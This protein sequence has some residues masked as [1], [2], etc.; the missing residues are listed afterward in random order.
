MALVYLIRCVY[1]VQPQ[2]V[3]FGQRLPISK[4]T[5]P[6]I[7]SWI[8]CI[9]LSLQSRHLQEEAHEKQAELS[10]IPHVLYLRSESTNEA[11]EISFTSSLNWQGVSEMKL[12]RREHHIHI[13]PSYGRNQR[14]Q[15]ILSNVVRYVLADGDMDY[16]TE[17]AVPI[18][19]VIYH[20][21]GAC[22]SPSLRR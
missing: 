11:I 3:I 17:T 16:T 13:H 18:P 7:S 9:D 6:R 19:A 15:A 21:H 20:Y 4:P 2:P 22:S 8:F 12:S 10:S 5:S 14:R 1:Q